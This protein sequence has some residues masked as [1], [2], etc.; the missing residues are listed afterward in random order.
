MCIRDS[1]KALQARVPDFPSNQMLLGNFFEQVGQYDLILVQTFFCSFPPTS[2]NR[3]LYAQKM[4]DLL[5]MNGKLVG[6]WFTFPLTGDMVKRPFGGTQE[7]YLSYL[8]PYF[9]KLT[10]EECYNSIPPRMG[11]ELFGIFQK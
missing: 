5:K 8:S 3:Q 1:L 11:N 7:E 10:F 9:K 6:L 2:T 4:Q